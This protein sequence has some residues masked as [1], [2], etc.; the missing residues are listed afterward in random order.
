MPDGYSGK[1]LTVP[2]L[3]SLALIA[4]RLSAALSGRFF[5]RFKLVESVFVHRSVATG[6]V[7]FARSDIDLLVVVRKPLGEAADG[8]ELAEMWRRLKQFRRLNPL[9]NHVEV[10]DREGLLRWFATDT[11][12]GSQERRSAWLVWGNHIDFPVLPVRREDAVR[13]FAVWGDGFF[14]TAVRERNRRNLR[15]T[16][17]EMWNAYATAVGRITEPFLLRR[18][19]AAH[20]AASGEAHLWRRIEN[21][22]R[23]APQAVFELA[24]CLHEARLGRIAKLS[25]PLIARVLMP[26]RYRHRTIVFVPDAWWPLPAESF[27]PGSSVCTPEMFHLYLHYWNPFLYWVLPEQIRE[28]G[29]KTPPVE[30]FIRACFFFGDNHTLRNP[31]FMHRDTWTPGA[32]V[33]LV[34]YVLPYLKEGRVPP[35]PE[36]QAVRAWINTKPEVDVYYRELFPKLYRE[37]ANQWAQL[38][39]AERSIRQA[40]AKAPIMNMNKS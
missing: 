11:Y 37:Y 25:Q 17:L 26:P 33:E 24:E 38:E 9:I 32:F 23:Q 4:Y 29:I 30:A 40:W 10:H 8:E 31:G 7:A 14:S 16:A 28:L 21:E 19:M 2:T 36:E 18:E 5:S 22:A 6:E 15:K 39:E 3:E 27:E 13:R 1:R 20:W 35:Q 12:R 34:R